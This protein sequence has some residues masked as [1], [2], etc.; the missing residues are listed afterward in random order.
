L[1]IRVLGISWP[2]KPEDGTV[3]KPNRADDLES[4]FHVLAWVALRATAHSLDLKTV[5]DLLSTTFDHCYLDDEGASR[6][7]GAKENA[8]L[9]SFVQ[10]TF[11]NDPLSYLLDTM[12]DTLAVRYEKPIARQHIDKYNVYM[13]LP[14]DERRNALE[15]HPVTL[16]QAKLANLEREDWLQVVFDQTLRL[17]GWHVNGQPVQREIVEC[18]FSSTRKRK[19]QR[20]SD[21]FPRQKKKFGQVEEEDDISD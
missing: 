2:L 12:A 6:G 9:N 17:E 14:E 21:L 11:K 10:V 19:S 3:P 15:Y 4:F 1:R 20:D 16:R 7:G 18:G 5:S 13:A 8:L